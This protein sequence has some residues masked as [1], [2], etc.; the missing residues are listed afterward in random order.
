MR[1]LWLCLSL[2]V[3][4]TPVAAQQG[5]PP[6]AEAPAPATP[7]STTT[8]P[9]TPA[10]PLVDY[11]LGVADKVRIIVFNE[12]T[13]SGEFTVSDSGTLS[14][15]LIG[16]VKAIGRTPREVIHDIEAKL[17]D[18]YLRQPR[19]SMDV[20]TYRPFYIL[21]EVTKPGEYPYSSGLSALNAVARAEGFTYRA[22]KRK[23]FIKRFG[24][25]AEKEYKLDSG[26]MVYPG[27]TV[28]VG[29]RYF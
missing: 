4:S 16:D 2:L 14:L 17:A 26:V 21:G 7:A 5:V 15:P 29:E 9:A 23:V 20:L 8:A 1:S 27:D 10:A 24:E 25:A 13:L 18:G 19:V 28:R 12:D 3:A 11:K 6:K 22:N